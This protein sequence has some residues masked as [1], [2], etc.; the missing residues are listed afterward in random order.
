MKEAVISKKNNEPHEAAG[1]RSLNHEQPSA[2]ICLV[3]KPDKLEIVAEI[4]TE[5][6]LLQANCELVSLYE[7]L[8]KFTLDRVWRE[9]DGAES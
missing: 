8:S 9:A 1:W 4:E 5:Q 2:N 6:A 3:P 7:T